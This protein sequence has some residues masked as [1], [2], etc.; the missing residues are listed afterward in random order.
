MKLKAKFRHF[1][2]NNKKILAMYM[3]FVSAISLLIN[4]LFFDMMGALCWFIILVLWKLHWRDER[5]KDAM[6][7]AYDIDMHIRDKE[8]STAKKNAFEAG[9]KSAMTLY[10][11]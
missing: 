4:V 5:T 7:R 6:Y 1:W 8:L 3:T 9:Y 2:R 10:S 11:K